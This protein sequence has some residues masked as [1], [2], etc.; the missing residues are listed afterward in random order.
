MGALQRCLQDQG[1]SL[2]TTAERLWA[3][4]ILQPSGAGIRRPGRD[5]VLS[6]AVRSP[7]VDSWFTHWPPCGDQGQ[8]LGGTITDPVPLIPQGFVCRCRWVESSK[9]REYQQTILV[10]VS[11]LA[12]VYIPEHILLLFTVRTPAYLS[13]PVVL[14]H[15]LSISCEMWIL[16][17][18]LRFLSSF[19][20]QWTS[21]E[22]KCLLTIVNSTVH[23][24]KIIFKS[25]FISL[26]LNSPPF[27]L[28]FFQSRQWKCKKVS[29][30]FFFYLPA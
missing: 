10:C 19:M 5:G 2:V 16:Q 27:F 25:L 4:R 18:G 8:Y 3:L 13:I 26:H 20:G 7:R 30:V 14:K 22:Q 28:N 15:S 1:H 9:Q 12:S 24:N 21:H 17:V 23:R 11:F 29:K 6:R